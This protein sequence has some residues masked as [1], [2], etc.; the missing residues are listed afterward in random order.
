MHFE[1]VSSQEIGTEWTWVVICEYCKVLLED[2]K[3]TQIFL[4]LNSWV[5]V[6]K[7]PQKEICFEGV[8]WVVD[9]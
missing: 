8:E 5:F 2:N 1:F 3:D 9:L 6:Q 4:V 7:G